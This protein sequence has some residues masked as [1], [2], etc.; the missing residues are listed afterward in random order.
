MITVALPAIAAAGTIFVGRKDVGTVAEPVQVVEDSGFEY[1]F[2][3]RAIVIFDSQQHLTS[4]GSRAGPHPFGVQHVTQMKPAGRR[5][6]KAST[7]GSIGL[8]WVLQGSTRF[9]RVRSGE[10]DFPDN[11]F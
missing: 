1:L 9:C 4:H 7:Q 8:Y 3:A 5:R 2:G 11:H 10:R 6:G